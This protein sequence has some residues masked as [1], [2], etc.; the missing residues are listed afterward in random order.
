MQVNQI[1]PGK[2]LSSDRQLKQGDI[3]R[4][5]TLNPVSETEAKVV[6]RGK[7]MNVTFEGRMPTS[8]TVSLQVTQVGDE[9]IQVREWVQEQPATSYKSA[10]GGSELEAAKKAGIDRPTPLLLQAIKTAQ[11]HGIPLTS[12]DIQALARYV[13]NSTDSSKLQTVEAL[14]SKRLPITDQHINAVHEALHGRPLTRTLT[15]LERIQQSPSVTKEDIAR[16]LQQLTNG[17]NLS[18][19]EKQFVD[20]IQTLLNQKGAETHYPQILQLIN[21][22]LVQTNMTETVANEQPA[23]GIAN[24]RDS[25]EHSPSVAAQLKLINQLQ[26]LIESEESPD[27]AFK[28]VQNALVGQTQFTADQTNRISSEINKASERLN[29][30]RE[31]AARQIVL[32]SLQQELNQLQALNVGEEQAQQTQS[33]SANP[34]AVTTVTEKMAALT[35][36][37]RDLQRE[38]S[39]TLSQVAIELAPAKPKDLHQSKNQLETVIRK[40]DHAILRGEYM[41]FADMK[42]EKS[43]MLAS[44]RLGEARKL[45]TSGNQQEAARIVSEVQKQ[46]DNVTFKPSETKIMHSSTMQQQL[47]KSASSPVQLLED[48]AIKGREGTARAVF[49]SMRQLGLTHEM[50]VA[51]KLSSRESP[52][53]MRNLKQSLMHMIQQE[54]GNRTTQ[55]ANQALNQLTGQQLLSKQDAQPIQ[56]LFFQLP[57]ILEQKVE[58]LQCYIQSKKEGEQVD[59]QNCSLYFLMETSKLGEIGISVRVVNR[60]LSVTLQNNQE[61]FKQRMEPLVARAIEKIEDIGYSISGIVFT[62]FSQDQTKDD[63]KPVSQ[64]V[65]TSEKGFDFKV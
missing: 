25:L 64:P 36:D 46:V 29:N 20:Q 63:V 61:E 47:A 57:L 21:Q 45:L 4:D 5:V 27:Q 10:N 58:Q 49:E 23:Q 18:T 42:T 55:L 48:A 8:G 12:E 3:L 50:E 56:S 62:P 19:S 54:E 11:G 65:Y 14:A 6:Y 38:V 16:L 51:Q 41:Q 26:R 59:W 52:G 43:L 35:T 7:E 60:Q 40:L 17:R 30:G 22:K 24:S 2:A 9:S 44:S 53:E 34:I 32:D 37:F 28:A 15:E 39:R 33:I 1:L 13:G 31:L